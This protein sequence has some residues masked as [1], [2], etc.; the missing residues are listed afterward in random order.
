MIIYKTNSRYQDG[1]LETF[2]ENEVIVNDYTFD[3]KS[4]YDYTTKSYFQEIRVAIDFDVD[5]G[6]GNNVSI[7]NKEYLIVGVSFGSGV[8]LG[9]KL[10]Q[11]I[12]EN[13]A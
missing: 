4:K 6:L 11:I 10:K 1:V 5:C 9:N 3:V 2:R 7:D 13:I 8:F 12:L